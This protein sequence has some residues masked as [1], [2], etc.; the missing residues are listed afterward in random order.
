MHNNTYW[1]SDPTSS[2]IFSV[3]ISTS[4]GLPSVV[5]ILSKFGATKF[6]THCPPR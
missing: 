5:S 4:N 3:S 1:V 6:K 2:V